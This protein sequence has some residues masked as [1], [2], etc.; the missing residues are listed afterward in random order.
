[1]SLAN[2]STSRE[3]CFIRLPIFSLPSAYTNN[4]LLEAG[5][6]NLPFSP[7]FGNFILNEKRLIVKELQGLDISLLFIK[8]QIDFSSPAGKLMFT[9]L[10]AIAE[11]ERDIIAERT[12]EGRKRAKAQGKPMGCIGKAEKDVKK[13]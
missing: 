13:L 7:N 2:S 6:G 5:F 12:A 4:L 9:M 3:V 1:M 10:G 8:D 11:F